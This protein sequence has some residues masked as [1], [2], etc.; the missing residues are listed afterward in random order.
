MT[1]TYTRYKMTC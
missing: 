1:Q